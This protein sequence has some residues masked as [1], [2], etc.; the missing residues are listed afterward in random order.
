MAL[1]QRKLMIP[2]QNR[3]K[4]PMLFIYNLPIIFLLDEII[5]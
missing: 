4:F 1:T 3:E 2:M 5:Q